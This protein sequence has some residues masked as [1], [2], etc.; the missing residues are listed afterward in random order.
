M[1]NDKNDDEDVWFSLAKQE[2]KKQ[3]WLQSWINKIHIGKEKEEEKTREVETFLC[4][5]VSNDGIKKF[6][7]LLN[8]G[9]DGNNKFIYFNDKEKQFLIELLENMGKGIE[10]LK[11]YLSEHFLLK[12]NLQLNYSPFTLNLI[13]R[14][15]KGIEKYDLFLYI[16]QVFKKS[17]GVSSNMKWDRIQILLKIRKYE[18]VLTALEDWIK[19]ENKFLKTSWELKC[20][21]EIK[22]GNFE[23]A[24]NSNEKW[25]HYLINQEHYESMEKWFCLYYRASILRY[26][27]D[28][29]KC[30]LITSLLK[31][32]MI[33]S[34][35]ADLIWQQKEWKINSKIGKEKMLYLDFLEI[36]KIHCECLFYK[37][38]YNDYIQNYRDIPKNVLIK[39]DFNNNNLDIDNQQKVDNKQKIDNHNNIVRILKMF[40]CLS[41]QAIGKY[42]EAQSFWEIFINENDEFPI[43]YEYIEEYLCYNNFCFEEFNLFQNKLDKIRDPFKVHPLDLLYMCTDSILQN[44]D[45]F[46][47]PSIIE[48]INNFNYWIP[49][50][51]WYDFEENNFLKDN[52]NWSNCFWFHNNSSIYKNIFWKQWNYLN[53]SLYFLFTGQIYMGWFLLSRCDQLP[54][55]WLRIFLYTFINFQ[56]PESLLQI[57]IGKE[58]EKNHHPLDQFLLERCK[59]EYKKLDDISNPINDTFNYDKNYDR[60][61]NK[62][63]QSSSFTF[64]SKNVGFKNESVYSKSAS[65]KKNINSTENLYNY[66]NPDDLDGR[67]IAKALEINLKEENEKQ[68][69]LTFSTLVDRWIVEHQDFPQELLDPFTF[70]IKMNLNQNEFKP[71]NLS[72]SFIDPIMINKLNLYE[73]LNQSISWKKFI[74][75][76]HLSQNLNI[77]IIDIF[78]IKSKEWDKSFF[79]SYRLKKKERVYSLSKQ[80][81]LSLSMMDSIKKILKNA[82]QKLDQKLNIIHDNKNELY[83]NTFAWSNFINLFQNNIKD[84]IKPIDK[85]F[86]KKQEVQKQEVQKQEI[87]IDEE[88]LQRKKNNKKNQNI[89]DK[90]LNN[91]NIN[92]ENKDEKVDKI[93]KK[94]VFEWKKD[95]NDKM[96]KYLDTIFPSL[97]GNNN[98]RSEFNKNDNMEN[99]GEEKVKDFWKLWIDEEELQET[100]Q[101]KKSSNI[102]DNSYGIYF[103]E[104]DNK[105]NKEND[106][107]EPIHIVDTTEFRF[108][109]EEM[110]DTLKEEWFP[111]CEKYLSLP[112]FYTDFPTKPFW[113]IIDEE[114]IIREKSSFTSFTWKEIFHLGFNSWIKY[115]KQNSFIYITLKSLFENYKPKFPQKFVLIY[116]VLLSNDMFDLKEMVKE[117]IMINQQMQVLPLLFM[118]SKLNLQ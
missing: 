76:P 113:F 112:K 9:N 18:Q 95:K 32:E 72:D 107:K 35:Y 22:L 13:M 80:E 118:Y 91:E 6:L 108:K 56:L 86:E 74:Y 60:N 99:W 79:A 20:L 101:E 45:R 28:Y 104:E 85:T 70:F 38:K 58:L 67:L 109:M 40:E 75:Q 63:K 19:E 117:E 33:L 59:H 14:S 93:D 89:V 51:I 50:P 77:E 68:K 37:K 100:E 31:K 116:G 102:N 16:Y 106:K 12:E 27:N 23:N 36:M 65:P 29:D 24:F 96:K 3:F 103:D 83:N 92:K 64:N 94:I 17:Y 114:W 97:G 115:Q 90:P 53:W 66:K 98:S 21:T 52:I 44:F 57:S 42:K 39:I 82:K 10:S 111:F 7:I 69:P 71:S 48:K 26:L 43:G 110:K 49:Q 34:E 78:A 11:E 4:S 8:D 30:L 2:R 73:N 55:N 1:D 61:D 47:H 88:P 81:S 5:D 62:N 46:E 84:S 105:D 15:C 25:Y 41:L 54:N 87:Q